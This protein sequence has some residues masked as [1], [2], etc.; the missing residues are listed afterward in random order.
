[1]KR[2]SAL[3]PR[4]AA[5]VPQKRW[6]RT[7]VASARK[8]WRPPHPQCQQGSQPSRQLH[9]LPIQ[10][11]VGPSAQDWRVAGRGYL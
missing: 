8:H 4:E 5:A 10:A 7:T 11:E 3:G 6:N 9:A 1:M 2:E